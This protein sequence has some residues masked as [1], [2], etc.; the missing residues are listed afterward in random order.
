MEI[1]WV[2]FR[3]GTEIFGFEIGYVRE[4][5]RM[6]RVHPVPHAA[7]D[8]LGVILLRSEV[9]PVFDLRRR[10]SMESAQQKSDMMITC[11]QDRLRDHE[12]WLTELE[13]SV[14]E[15]REFTLT[16]DP[17]KCKF[18]QWYDCFESEDPNLTR[19]MRR[20]R[21][22]HEQ[23]HGT[24]DLVRERLKAN[25]HAEALH[26]ID[27]ARTTILDRLRHT[28]EEAIDQIRTQAQLSLIVIGAND[29]TIGLAV[30]EIC[31]VAACQE[32]DIESPESIPHVEQFPGLIGL[33]P[34]KGSSRLMML[35]DPQKI[36]PSQLARVA[37]AEVC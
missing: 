14:R 18:G 3:V 35:L 26:L 21:E 23:I 1:Q 19:I 11:L 32:S 8:S 7:F 5:L 24:A 12:D 2:T 22:P 9:V 34:Q 28:F 20:F 15:N 4:M 13:A 33:L 10:F 30:D 6:P 29:R 37:E 17:H 25:Q 27:A 36:Y 31:A 16:T